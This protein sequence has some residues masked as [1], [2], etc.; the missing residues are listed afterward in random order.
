MLKIDEKGHLL[1]AR[2]GRGLRAELLRFMQEARQLD[3][4]GE[5]PLQVRDGE[6]T[7]HARVMRRH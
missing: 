6:S 3:G 5:R 1:P 2:E 4:E 7:D